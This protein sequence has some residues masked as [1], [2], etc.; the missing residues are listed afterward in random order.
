MHED[1]TGCPT[2]RRTWPMLLVRVTAVLMVG[3][4]VGFA[5]GRWAVPGGEDPQDGATTAPSGP[6]ADDPTVIAVDEDRAIASPQDQWYAEREFTVEAGKKYLASFRLATVKPPEADGYVMFLGVSFRCAP[7]DAEWG[8][9]AARSS[10]GGTENLLPGEPVL[11]SNRMVLE[12]T[13]S[14]TYRCGIYANSPYDH[15]AS[16]GTTIDLDSTWNV[17]EMSGYAAAV[18]P[19]DSLPKVVPGTKT[20]PVLQ[21]NIPIDEIDS[22]R[23]TV[24]STLQVTSCTGEGGSREA[25]RTWCTPEVIDPSG[26]RFD[27]ILRADLVDGNGK[28]CQELDSA[29][30]QVFLSTYRHHQSLPVPSLHIQVPESPCGDTV[31]VRV[32]IDNTG[33]AGLLVHAGSTSLVTRAS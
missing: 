9:E 28:P 10:V 13:K 26:A 7:T 16:N 30:R 29:S 14:G 20:Q 32:E 22:D 24:D 8:D 18:E 27:A 5:L 25:G 21:Q 31:R 23:L 1:P 4:L 17:E 33:P 11:F 15:L 6:T 3:V 2:T 19:S 12:P